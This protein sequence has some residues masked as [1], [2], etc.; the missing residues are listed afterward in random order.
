MGFSRNIAA[1][2]DVLPPAGQLSHYTRW[3]NKDSEQKLPGVG[4]GKM[5]KRQ[6][7]KYKRGS[8]KK[9]KARQ[10]KAA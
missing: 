2:S 7:T 4:W 5:C 9:N 8:A 3:E 6:K 1:L 10:E